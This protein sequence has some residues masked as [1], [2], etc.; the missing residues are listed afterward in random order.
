VEAS[1]RQATAAPAQHTASML[2]QGPAPPPV[3]VGA[4]ARSQLQ[5]GPTERLWLESWIE[6][7]VQDK[8]KEMSQER[9]NHRTK[10]MNHHLRTRDRII[11]SECQNERHVR[12]RVNERHV[13]MRVNERHVRVNE[14]HVRRTCLLCC[15]GAAHAM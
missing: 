1:P 15:A 6:G 4:H 12:M 8:G 13:R 14:R 9:Q 10:G 3:S 5:R 11:M 7:H 2:C